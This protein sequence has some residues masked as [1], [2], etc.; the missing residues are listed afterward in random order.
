[1]SRNVGHSGGTEVNGVCGS[2]SDAAG[3]PE[4][5]ELGARKSP[6]STDGLRR[7]MSER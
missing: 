5:A 2:S 4:P 7:G 1:V 3:T 6:V